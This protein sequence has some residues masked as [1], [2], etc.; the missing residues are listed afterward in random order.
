MCEFPWATRCS[1]IR[2]IACQPLCD[3]IAFK[4]HSDIQSQPGD[5]DF[6]QCLELGLQSVNQEKDSAR[7]LQSNHYRDEWSVDA[8]N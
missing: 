7:D 8:L 3:R 1:Q 6:S 4:Q 2:T 5:V